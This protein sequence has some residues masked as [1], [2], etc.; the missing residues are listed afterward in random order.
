MSG[1]VLSHACILERYLL[2]LLQSCT[3]WTYASLEFCIAY[4]LENHKREI[5]TADRA[6]RCAR[7]YDAYVVY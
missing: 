4:L 6:Y 7:I 3:R 2:N 5:Q 1:A